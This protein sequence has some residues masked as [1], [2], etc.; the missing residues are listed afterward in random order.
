MS[1]CKEFDARLRVVENCIVELN[2]TN[3]LV[4]VVLSIV[5]LSFGID[6]TGVM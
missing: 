2:T 5:C 4:K 3:K 6:V 1:D